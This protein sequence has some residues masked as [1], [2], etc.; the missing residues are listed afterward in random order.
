MNTLSTNNHG[1]SD[2][3]IASVQAR[4][5][6][7][8]HITADTA[9]VRRIAGNLEILLIRRKN[10]PYRNCWALPGGFVEP[11]E[12]LEAAARR[13]LREETGIV[14]SERLPLRQVGAYGNPSR[15][16]RGRVVSVVYFAWAGENELLAPRGD[17]D[18]SEA[19]FVRFC[20]GTAFDKAGNT[21]P[22]AFDHEMIVSDVWE[23]ARRTV[24]PSFP[25]TF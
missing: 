3:E 21:L 15:D 14:I 1:M 5:G 16:P 4:Y 19:A 24:D 17:D 20:G 9:F 22:L 2:S 18:A 12:D 13:E 23:I 6:K 7:G 11:D 8:P 10:K 25:G